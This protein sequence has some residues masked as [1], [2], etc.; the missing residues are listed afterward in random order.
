MKCVLF[1]LDGTLVSTGGAGNRALE[2]AFLMLYNI[3]NAMEHIDP[4]GKVDPAIIREIFQFYLHRDCSED[5]MNQV[6]QKYLEFL[7]QE[8][9]QS[10]HYRVMDGIHSLLDELKRREVIMGLGTGNLEQ[11]A[12]IKLNRA[13]LNH[14]FPFGGY[15][16]D[17]ESR[18]DLLKIG[19]LKAKRHSG[20]DLRVEDV[21]V[22]GDTERD[23]LAAQKSDFKVISVATGHVSSEK[24]SKFSPD[25]LL[26]NFKDRRRFMEIIF[27]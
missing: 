16:S 22:V 18:P 20:K 27:S 19:F 11:G 5:E 25:F 9:E 10:P 17:S 8:C 21:F 13:E 24:L 1:D 26:E 15:G 2:K 23:I 6:Q 4:A 14:Y 12:R 7:P 3:P